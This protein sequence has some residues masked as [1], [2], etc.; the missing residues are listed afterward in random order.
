[1]RAASGW[2]ALAGLL[3]AGG[4][5]PAQQSTEAL[6]EEANEHFRSGNQLLGSDP[7]GAAGMYRR[8]ALRYESLVSE[9]G[10]VNSKLY[11]NL[12]NAYLRL[13][14]V[15][16]AIL[17]YRKAAHLDPADGNVTRNL[18]HARTMR[19]DKLESEG[20]S[21]IVETL[22][23]W[24]YDFA[25]D[26]RLRLFAGVWIGFWGVVVLRLL[27]RSWVPREIAIALGAASALILGSVALDAVQARSEVA[28]VVIAPDTV[29]RQGDGPSY[30]PSFEEPLHAGAEFRLLEE[31][32]GW[33]RVELP[34]GRR[35]WLAAGDVELVLYGRS[36]Q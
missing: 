35:C 10:I 5:L 20:G 4:L 33:Y 31:R 34:D 29:A 13:G 15:G 25:F 6:F 12:A 23:F 19:R 27:G 1:M 18:E 26:T 30:E 7:E 22:L 36:K 14:D 32:P 8:A 28:G 17:N 9:R 24:H 16:R 11:Y 3:C 21:Q 2:L